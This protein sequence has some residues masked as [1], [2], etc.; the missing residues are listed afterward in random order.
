MPYTKKV[1]PLLSPGK[2]RFSGHFA[3]AQ[4]RSDIAKYRH[5]EQEGFLKNYGHSAAQLKKIVWAG[6]DAANFDG[7][8]GGLMEQ[9]QSEKES[10]FSCPVR[11]Y[12]R[13]GLSLIQGEIIHTENLPGRVC[14]PKI[15]GNQQWFQNATAA[16]RITSG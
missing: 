3:Y 8:G 2:S 12:E 11:T 5:I 14:P 15:S 1:E 10:C 9:G 16:F 6:G 7:P 4:S 13:D